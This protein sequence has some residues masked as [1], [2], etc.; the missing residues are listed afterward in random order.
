MNVGDDVDI[1]PR[2][3]GAEHRLMIHGQIVSINSGSARV[4]WC[5]GLVSGVGLQFLRPCGLTLIA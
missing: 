5:D 2:H 3:H 4:R 1:V